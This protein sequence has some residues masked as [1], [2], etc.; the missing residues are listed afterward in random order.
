MKIENNVLKHYLKNVYFIT[1]TAYAGKSTMCKMLAERYDMLL[2]GE[3]V[4][5]I[6]T[7]EC[8]PTTNSSC[9]LT[10]PATAYRAF[11]LA[12]ICA[13]ATVGKAIIE[14][15][16][17]TPNNLIFIFLG[18]LIVQIYEIKVKKHTYEVCFLVSIDF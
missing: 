4:G 16:S 6:A 12:Y 3:K 11:N 10:T 17:N 7:E 9:G 8:G 5:S 13:C 15:A 14:M 1:G 18:V 2:C